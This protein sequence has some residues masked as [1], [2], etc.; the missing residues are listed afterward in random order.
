MF[1]KK[2]SI[3]KGLEVKIQDFDEEEKTKKKQYSEN[4]IVSFGIIGSNS[5]KKR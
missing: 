2:K 3:N 5:I 1:G 4:N